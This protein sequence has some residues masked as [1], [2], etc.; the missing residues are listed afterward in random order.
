MDQSATVAIQK[1][2]V[3]HVVETL[4]IV[5]DHPHSLG[6]RSGRMVSFRIPDF[7]KERRLALNLSAK[8][9]PGF[10]ILVHLHCTV[11]KNNAIVGA[12]LAGGISRTN[13][14]CS[15]LIVP[16]F[17]I[18]RSV[19]ESMGRQELLPPPYWS[20]VLAKPRFR[21]FPTSCSRSNR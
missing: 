9:N 21:R 19:F 14:A 18:S 11:V 10:T 4:T 7:S 3:A 6:E 13:Q 1:R 15:D 17:T 16:A 12:K 8:K 20:T 5:S 2:V